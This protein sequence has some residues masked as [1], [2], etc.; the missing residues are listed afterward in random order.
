MK[1]NRLTTAIGCGEP[2]HGLR[3]LIHPN[4]HLP[5]HFHVEGGNIDASFTIEDCALIGGNVRSNELD[6]V[7]SF[8]QHARPLL[9]TRW[10][11]SGPP[12]E[13][14][15]AER[16]GGRNDSTESGAVMGV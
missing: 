9:R 11:N 15:R 6:L 16:G 2:V 10:E 12:I 4:D 14:T 3:I 8:H 5:P 1:A 7:R 13:L